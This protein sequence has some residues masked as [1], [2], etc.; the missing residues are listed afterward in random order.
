MNDEDSQKEHDINI[1]MGEKGGGQRPPPLFF[2]GEVKNFRW[3]SNHLSNPPQHV[4]FFRWG[5]GSHLPFFH[6]GGGTTT[7]VFLALFH[8][9]IRGGPPPHASEQFL[10]QQST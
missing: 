4:V 5:G 3:S 7:S 2:Y 9:A 6:K 10:P 1:R 8:S